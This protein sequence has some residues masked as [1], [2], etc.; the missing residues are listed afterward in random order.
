MTQEEVDLLNLIEREKALNKMRLLSTAR[1]AGL[2]CSLDNTASVEQ[3]FS[4]DSSSPLWARSAAARARIQQQ[5]RRKTADSF[6]KSGLRID[7]ALANQSR[8][9]RASFPA[10]KS[11][12]SIVSSPGEDYEIDPKHVSKVVVRSGVPS[13]Y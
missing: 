10:P 9:P 6:G 5:M 8:T 11:A 7:P 13:K 1:K 2:A 3:E 4:Q 12:L